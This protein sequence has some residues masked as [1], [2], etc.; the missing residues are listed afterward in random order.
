MPFWP[1]TIPAGEN[2]GPKPA[3]IEAIVFRNL[4]LA[5]LRTF[6]VAARHQSLAKASQELNLTDSAD[7]GRYEGCRGSPRW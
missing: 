2:I 4:P 7:G 1:G 5:T 6:D 3:W